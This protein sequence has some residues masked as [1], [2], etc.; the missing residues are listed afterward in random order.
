MAIE[1]DDTT[2]GL[3]AKL[4]KAVNEMIGWCNKSGM[5]LN[6]GKTKMMHFEAK[7]ATTTLVVKVKQNQVEQKEYMRYLGV[8]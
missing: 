4:Q 7:D 2:N 1:T 8:V 3:Q 5:K 6:A